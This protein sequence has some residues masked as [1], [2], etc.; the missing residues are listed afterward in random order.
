MGQPKRLERRVLEGILAVLALAAGAGCEF[1]PVVN[2]AYA[3]S[4][5]TVRPDQGL[6]GAKVFLEAP[7][8]KR[9]VR[10]VLGKGDRW[11]N[12]P[13][14][15]A[16]DRTPPTDFVK[17]ALRRELAAGGVKLVNAA[18]E[19]DRVVG[20][21]LTRLTV[22]E[23]NTYKGEIEL[24]LLVKDRDGRLV[25]SRPVS[26]TDTLAGTERSW[27]MVRQVLSN[28]AKKAVQ[29]GLALPDVQAAFR[30][31]GRQIDMVH[32]LIAPAIV[33]TSETVVDYVREIGG[34]LL[35]AS[36]RLPAGTAGMATPAGDVQFVVVA[37]PVPNAYA[38]GGQYLY[39]T[40][41]LVQ[42]CEAEEELGSAL[43]HALAHA[44]LRHA[45]ARP[46]KPSDDPVQVA[47]QLLD[48]LPSLNEDTAANELGFKIYARAGW[49]PTRH[50]DVF[51]RLRSRYGTAG[52][53]APDVAA[54]LAALPAAAADWR[55][56][57]RQPVA[58]ERSFADLRVR[59]ERLSGYKE[60][61]AAAT[62]AALPNCF[63]R[64]AAQHQDALRQL[65]KYRGKVRPGRG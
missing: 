64:N 6:A 34:R 3:P 22:L 47:L 28:A 56:W 2:L 32:Q 29:A 13:P 40:T 37:C 61:P 39:V 25:L 14:Y 33:P 8:D 9:Q 52:S 59:A 65:G 26:G 51:N 55:T 7:E 60:E 57:R 27:S 53:R 17:E 36:K 31:T 48:P 44:Q 19:A 38:T 42:V 20:A 10:D 5:R 15:T 62:A 54:Y 18:A 30:D 50:A 4:L 1:D 24:T 11:P 49:E 58:D 63:T 45:A 12:D 23:T 43:A 35:D 41:G 21:D 16:S 46:S